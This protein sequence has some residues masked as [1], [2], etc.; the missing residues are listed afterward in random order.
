LTLDQRKL[1]ELD[2]RLKEYMLIVQAFGEPNL[3]PLPTP[4]EIQTDQAAAKRKLDMFRLA[5][6]ENSERLKQMKAPQA[7]PLKMPEGTPAEQHWHP[8]PAAFTKAFIQTRVMGEDA[9]PATVSFTEILTAYRAQEATKFNGEVARYEA[10][11]AKEKPPLY[12]ADKMV[13]EATFNRAAP[14]T[15]GAMLY[16]C[17]FLLAIFGWLFRYQPLNWAALTL[18]VLTV[19]FH[20]AA[21]WMRI[22]ISGRPPVTNLYSSAVFIGWA[23]AVFGLVLEA[24]Y[25][26]G[27]G[28]VVSAV[29]GFA[30]LLIAGLL[31][32]GGEDTVG[33]MQAVLD[34]QFWLATHVVCI[35]L[36]YAATFIAGLFGLLYLILGIGSPNLNERTR[37]D[38][39]RMIYGTVCFAIFFSFVGTVLGG[40]WA[41]DSWGRFWGWDPKEN[42]AL[43]IV[44]WNALVLHAR[45]DKMV[46]DR[47]LAVLAVGGNIVT[48]WSWFGVNQLGIGLHS[49]GFTSGVVLALMT[50][51]LYMLV[52]IAFGAL[53]LAWWWSRQ[54]PGQPTSRAVGVGISFLT[55]NALFLAALGVQA[56]QALI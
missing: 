45:W 11:L 22:D 40:L 27:L 1:L 41:D 34:T 38:M 4:E 37:K 13:S 39:A 15:L 50:F 9:D 36:G 7:I 49:Y 29:A 10:L 28:N 33:V 19:L 52:C 3:P 8:Y 44:L 31:A 6:F 48:A 47:G 42:G 26:V 18:L 54:A 21:L 43:I 24:I 17:V 53:P 55:F 20:T 2:G 12:S 5:I 30:T 51:G 14:F 35:T 32:S 56:Y 46:A 16:F 23:C 25:R